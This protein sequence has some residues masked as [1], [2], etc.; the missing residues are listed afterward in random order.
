MQEWL[1]TSETNGGRLRLLKNSDSQNLGP[2][3]LFGSVKG[4]AISGLTAC[5]RSVIV[6]VAALLLREPNPKEP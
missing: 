3:Y 6:E 5:Q 4:S 1:F 2:S